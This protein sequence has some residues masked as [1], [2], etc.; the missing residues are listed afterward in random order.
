M[1]GHYPVLP[2]VLIA[3]FIS[4]VCILEIGFGLFFEITGGMSYK[5]MRIW[6]KVIF[7]T[8]CVYALSILS[9]AIYMLAGLM[10]R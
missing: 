8:T 10:A 3:T 9:I 4:F 5:I 2:F 1:E 7:V 6:A